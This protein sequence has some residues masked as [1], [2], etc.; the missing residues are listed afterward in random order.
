MKN[1]QQSTIGNPQSAFPMALNID[2]KYFQQLGRLEFLAKQAVEGFITGLH[3][4]PFHGFSVEFAEHR[5]YNTGESTRHIDWKLYAR[6]E[7]LF[8][9]R[10]EEET[11]LRCQLVIDHSS[12]MYYP[13]PVSPDSDN[14]NK[15]K[16]SVYAAAALIELFKRQRDAVGLSLFAE[17]LDTQTT[18]RSNSAHHRFLYTHLEALLNTVGEKEQSKTFA[19]DALHEIAEKVNRRSLVIVFSDM[20]DNSDK[21]DE[22]FA[23]L[24]HLRH[25]KHEVIIFHV[26]DKKTELEFDFPNRPHTFV[27]LESGEEIKAN[28]IDIR[29]TYLEQME[30]FHQE[31][32]VRC[33]QYHIDFI[34]ADV[35]AGV[36]PVLMQYMLKRQ[37]L[38]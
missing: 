28:P 21:R 31:L 27:D 4:S 15:L 29:Q 14:F 17:D 33:G 26:V 38:F 30:A 3:K 10:Y 19:V 36:N 23:A 34:E 8:T 9:K 16:F 12:S 7:K 11:N 25:N 22:L 37:K 32:K 2:R 24:Q 35:N 18:A 13:G 1:Y 5:L 20:L 6:T